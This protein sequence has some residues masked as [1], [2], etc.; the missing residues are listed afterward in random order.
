MSQ[1]NKYKIGDIVAYRTFNNTFDHGIIVDIEKNYPHIIV[2]FFNIHD[3][4][5][6]FPFDS[7]HLIKLTNGE[8]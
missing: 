4:T 2:K 3:G 5:Y 7:T 1:S 6:L 8:T